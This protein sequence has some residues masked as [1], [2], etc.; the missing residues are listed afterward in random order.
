MRIP[1][2]FKDAGTP[3]LTAGLQSESQIPVSV[4]WQPSLAETGQLT[5]ARPVVSQPIGTGGAERDLITTEL[6]KRL[7]SKQ[8]PAYSQ[9]TV[10]ST[11]MMF[12][13]QSP[14]PLAQQALGQIA[15][16]CG[17]LGLGC[18]RNQSPASPL[19]WPAREKPTGVRDTRLLSTGDHKQSLSF[20]DTESVGPEVGQ[21]YQ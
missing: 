17:W 16:S 2:A 18:L 21:L 7:G 10:P 6:G 5:L 1:T 3:Q 8:D 20:Q 13:T 15:E 14:H 4:R 12:T 11:G 9:S 19:A